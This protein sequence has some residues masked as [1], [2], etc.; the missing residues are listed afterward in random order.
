MDELYPD[1]NDSRYDFSADSLVRE[2]LIQRLTASQL[3]PAQSRIPMRLDDLD[4]SDAGGR[5]HARDLSP[6]RERDTPNADKESTK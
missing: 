1:L 3:G 4:A 5:A 2:S 6:L